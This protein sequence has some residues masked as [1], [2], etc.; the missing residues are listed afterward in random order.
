MSTQRRI[1]YLTPFA[2]GDLS[3]GAAQRSHFLYEALRRLGDVTV[4]KTAELEPRGT[5]RQGVRKAVCLFFPGLL[6]PLTK[7]DLGRFDV[8]V[9]RY[10]RT[11]A[12]YAAWR[13]GPLYIDVDDL[14]V[15]VCPRGCRFV[16]RR[17]TSWVVRHAACVW[18]ANPQD[19]GRLAS[20]CGGGVRILPLENIALPPR[21]GYRFE[22]PRANRVI[23]VA[24]LGYPPNIQGI[25]RFL[26]RRWPTMRAEN[27]TLA[28]RVIGKGLPPR[29][30]AKWKKI[31]GVELAGF[32]DDID[33]EYEA[34]RAVV[35]P[36]ETGGGTNVKVLEAMA[37]RREVIAP[38]FA[39]R[40]IGSRCGTFDDF[41]AQ[42]SA[43]FASRRRKIPV[44]FSVDEK[45]LL[46][47][48]IAIRSL[49]ASRLA[50]TDYDI[51]VLASDLRPRSRRGLVRRFPN[52]RIV[53]VSNKA[54]SGA[55]VGHLSRSTY[56]RLLLAEALSEYDR[57]I[58]SDADV[59]FYGDLSAVYAADYGDFDWAGVAMERHGER[60]GLHNHF[61]EN[62]NAFVYAAGFMVA[63]T[64]AWR[65]RRL[66]E[67]FV[68]IVRDFGTRLTMN[69]LD[70][71]NLATDRISAVPF[72][73][74]V[75]ESIRE[76]RSPR[77]AKEYAF[78]K[79]VY[80]DAE[81]EAA[82]AHPVIVHYC[83]V[84]PKVWRRS[85]LEMPA[86]YRRYWNTSP[87]K[88]NWICQRIADLKFLTRGVRGRQ[89]RAATEF[90]DK[91]EEK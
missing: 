82:K 66:K 73:Y 54:F 4:V 28:Y 80:S 70:V 86:E 41:A 7:V 61:P 87:F 30:A 77:S 72:S 91:K 20:A 79:N 64:K 51:V 85:V 2:T 55:P 75:F 46:P 83:G 42:V 58:W 44:V 71:L 17:W 65:E 74:C 22:A 23:T 78:L 56:N 32:V 59:V 12:Y 62:G 48:E 90:H 40:G 16:F 50:T 47:L 38:A 3:C 69:D 31:P 6:L 29:L 39:W 33:R 10:V 8:V 21:P 24:H 63:N 57:V 67:R 81:L 25:D 45:Y 89:R 26:K 19:A 53:S 11:A 43:A 9:T 13:F 1:L 88:P 60:A 14:P 36:I 35:C 18:V 84:N 5:I 37:H 68:R 15:D 34:C 52:V 76:G 27:P 49:M